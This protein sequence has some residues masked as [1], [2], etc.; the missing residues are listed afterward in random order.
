MATALRF[1]V[2]PSMGSRR[3]NQLGSAL[4]AFLREVLGD[5]FDP[6]VVI[7]ASYGEA[8]EVLLHGGAE[9]GWLPPFVSAR[10][11]QG[12]GHAAVRA[13]RG[14]SSSFRIA[15]V[16]H[17]H[18]PVS[19]PPATP[20]RA[21]WVDAQSSGYLLPRL[22]LE[23]LRLDPAQIFSEQRFVGS[24]HAALM[25]VLEGRADLTGIFSSTASAVRQASALELLSGLERS[26]L[27]IVD[28]TAE[29]PNDAVVTA[30]G[31]DPALAAEVKRRLLEAASTPSGSAAVKAI[32]DADTLESAP[33]SGYRTLLSIA[34]T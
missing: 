6:R 21:A 23:A 12:G 13:V 32:F 28:Y 16:C 26:Q 3:V 14:G 18:R 33:Q 7:A 19:L 34:R 2:P 22:H 29:C 9:V 31:L 17:S 10:V 25:E 30:S 1:V 15:L 5:R 11:V 24:Y 20:V 4:E 8:A 27:R